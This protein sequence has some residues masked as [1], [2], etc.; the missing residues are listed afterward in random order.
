MDSA[1]FKAFVVK[2]IEDKKYIREIVEKNIDDLPEGEVLMEVQYSSLNYK[3]ALSAHG[4]KGVTRNYPHTPGIDAAGIVAESSSNAFAKGDKILITGYDL[5]M[6]TSG[7]FQQYIRVPSSWVIKLPDNLSLKEAMTYGTAG[8]TAALSVYKLISSGIKPEDG[9]ILVTGS[10]GGVG[11]IA[12]ALLANLGY[13]VVGVTGKQDKREMLLD[14]GVYDVISREEADDKSGKPLLKGRWAGVID[15]VGG[16]ILA[17]AIKST[18]YGGVVTCC[19]NAASAELP[20]SVYPFI[21][22]GIS[23]LGVDSVQCPIDLRLKI[24]EL[25]SSDWKVDI[26]SNV[27]E[28]TLEELEQ[29][30]NLILQG[31]ISGRVIVNLKK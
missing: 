31:K 13:L 15:T 29:K 4:N 2:E 6:N 5:G 16:N 28:I 3:D 1:K 9:E 21:L 11:S 14:L 25:L 8:F 27:E 19:G 22:R 18:E 10:T 12:A 26:S 7:G 30:I 24:W 20:A 17:T 23:L